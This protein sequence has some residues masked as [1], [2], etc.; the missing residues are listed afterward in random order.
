MPATGVDTL[1]RT[2]Q[3]VIIGA[4]AIGGYGAVIFWFS[5]A[6]VYNTHFFDHGPLL[7]FYNLMRI[8]LAVAL[9]W[10][11]YAVGAVVLTMVAGFPAVRALSPAERYALGFFT[12]AGL[13]HIALIGIGLSGGYTRPVAVMLT[14]AAMV[15]SAPHL[16]DCLDEARRS[17]RAGLGRRAA[18]FLAVFAAVALLF[19]CIKT[20]YPIGGNDYFDHYFYYYV[21]VLRSGSLVPNESWYHFFYSKGLGLH[22][23]GMLLSDPLAAATISA[24]FVF[25]AALVVALILARAAPGTGLPWIGATLY[26]GLMIFTPTPLDLASAAGWAELAK[27]HEVSAALFVGGFWA[28]SRCG[29][30]T[31]NPRV[32]LT[33]AIGATA[34]M[35]LVASEMAII[36]GAFFV[37]LAIW[38]G[39]TRNNRLAAAALSCAAVA[40]VALLTVAAINYILTGIPLDQVLLY[41]WPLVD[42]ERVRRWGVLN[43]VLWLH[44]GQTG[45]THE[46]VTLGWAA[47]R[48]LW[49]DFR[50]DLLWPI[51]A[52][53][54]GG[55]ALALYRGE[56]RGQLDRRARAFWVS[57]AAFAVSF[58]PIALAIGAGPLQAQSLYRF[59]SFAFAPTLCAVLLLCSAYPLSP[60]R[61]ALGAAAI[62]VVL[63]LSGETGKHGRAMRI[64]IPMLT[65]DALAFVGGGMSLDEA[66][67]AVGWPG[68]YPWG[69]IYSGMAAAWKIAGRGVPIYSLDMQSYCMLPDCRVLH[70]NDTRTIPDFETVLFGAPDEAAAA[71]K[72]AGI[73]YFFHSIE[74]GDMP[75][76]IMT[77]IILSP[78][79]APD[80]LAQYFGVK[81]TDGTSYLLTWRAAAE[82]PLDES[83]LTAYRRQVAAAPIRT[84]FPLAQWHEVFEHF[85]AY[86]LHPYRLPWCVICPGVPA[87]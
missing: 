6:D 24:I 78:L 40:A 58:S 73:D 38:G 64:G 42:L 70:W 46:T 2:A 18:G 68:R 25:A 71:I 29:E 4:A 82:K 32:W 62:I 19:V 17:L 87:N 79:F 23:L 35:V 8:A 13:W 31:E 45:F 12:G 7:L 81:W 43:D 26:I 51:L 34:A 5:W 3:V 16:A 27:G 53:G 9:A 75:P 56:R 11:V 61:V 39:V 60:R 47:L 21:N 72:R 84:S 59:S 37:V 33:A 44:Y 50:L 48:G 30:E 36:G 65:G 76:G 57:L 15:L 80:T 83:F 67:R 1:S 22:F 41:L 28:T 85:R 10:L 63:V 54:L 52:F 74:L 69:G 14:M 66:F 55:A 49:R 77:P 86:G 20:L